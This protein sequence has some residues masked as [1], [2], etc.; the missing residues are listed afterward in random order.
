MFKRLFQRF[1]KKRNFGKELVLVGTCI[2]ATED[3]YLLYDEAEQALE[4]VFYWYGF[5]DAP[6]GARM[7]NGGYFPITSTNIV[8]IME[9]SRYVHS[10]LE[11]RA[12]PVVISNSCE[13]FTECIADFSSQK[14]GV[15]N[16]NQNIDLTSGISFVPMQNFSSIMTEKSD[17]ELLS[18]GIYEDA[19]SPSD[20]NMAKSMSVRWVSSALFSP[21]NSSKLY[22]ELETFIYRND[23]IALNIDLRTIVRGM[24]INP[25]FA[26]EFETV[27]SIIQT[28]MKSNKVSLVHLTGDSENLI[29]SNEAKKVLDVIRAKREDVNY[30]A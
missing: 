9:F 13:S 3:S 30:A 8:E 1:Y 14:V 18:L 6:Y 27:L 25:P 2:K 5:T 28:L 15:V 12:L 20:I 7:T 23:C 19:I 11:Y 16:I 29:F 22:R 26:L 10:L 21:M 17:V 24:T 4:Y